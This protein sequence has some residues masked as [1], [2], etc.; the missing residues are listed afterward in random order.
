[1]VSK[2]AALD[3]SGLFAQNCSIG[4]IKILCFHKKQAELLTFGLQYKTFYNSNF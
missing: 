4:R 2:L 1:M 3:V